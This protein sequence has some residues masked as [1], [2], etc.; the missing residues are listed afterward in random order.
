[1]HI[2]SG[3]FSATFCSAVKTNRRYFVACG[4][5]F[6]YLPKAGNVSLFFSRSGAC[7][8]EC[9]CSHHVAN[10]NS[11]LKSTCTMYS[12]GIPLVNPSAICQLFR[13]QESTVLFNQKWQKMAKKDNRSQLQTVREK[14]SNKHSPCTGHGM[15][16][17]RGHQVLIHKNWP[18]STIG[19][20]HTV[21]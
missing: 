2:G 21:T 19:C 5:S 18:L 13:S 14:L 10:V 1:M 17:F 3:W 20:C 9:T 7:I 16:S 8:N 12:Q 15:R 4:R 11:N 6:L